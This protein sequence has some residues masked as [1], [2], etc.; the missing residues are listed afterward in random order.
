MHSFNI[1]EYIET[2]CFQLERGPTFAVGI[3]LH[4]ATNG[5]ICEGCPKFN[6]GK[7]PDYKKM[8]F[9]RDNQTQPTPQPE[10]VREESIRRDISIS[11]VRRQRNRDT[12]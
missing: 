12:S 9:N 8:V 11:E 4:L 6:G 5:K 7:C 2:D 3:A 1:T 10:T